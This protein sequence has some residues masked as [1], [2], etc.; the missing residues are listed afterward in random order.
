MTIT[1]YTWQQKARVG[2]FGKAKLQLRQPP[3]FKS[4]TMFYLA[5]CE[6]HGFY[7]DY[8]HGF[9]G[10]EYLSCPKCATANAK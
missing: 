10:E 1:Y 8:L 4:P 9:E 2:M 6:E 5:K 7:E 3:N